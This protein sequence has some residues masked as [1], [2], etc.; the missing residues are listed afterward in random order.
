MAI[1]QYRPEL[2]KRRM[3]FEIAYEQIQEVMSRTYYALMENKQSNK[4]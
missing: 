3:S 1:D 4:I 2:A